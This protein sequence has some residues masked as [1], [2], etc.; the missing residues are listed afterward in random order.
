MNES[1]R[2]AALIC[3]HTI[4]SP[5]IQLAPEQKSVKQAADCFSNCKIYNTLRAN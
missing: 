3:D 1:Y 5:E 2:N 4:Y